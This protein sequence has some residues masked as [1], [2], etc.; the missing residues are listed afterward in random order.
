MKLN[1]KRIFI[2]ILLTFLAMKVINVLL[3][4]PIKDVVQIWPLSTNSDGVRLRIPVGYINSDVMWFEPI[5]EKDKPPKKPN[6]KTGIE[7]FRAWWPTMQPVA[8]NLN[9]QQIKQ[10][11]DKGNELLGIMAVSYDKRVIEKDYRLLHKLAVYLEAEFS[12]MLI[13]DDKKKQL[14]QWLQT[15]PISELNLLQVNDIKADAPYGY[16][17]NIGHRI[18]NAQTIFFKS[19]KVG[20]W[21][22][23]VIVCDK[24]SP[25]NRIEIEV[26]QQ[27]FLIPELEMEV[28]VHYTKKYLAQW[29]LIQQKTTDMFLS[30]KE[31]H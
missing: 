6:E 16:Y 10:M 2:I 21:P 22:E 30:F 11:Q 24:K 20:Q 29:S 15:T 17:P 25:Q 31:Q 23:V 27:S 5:L 7:L 19:S 18:A 12:A 9:Y 14:L 4:Q 3:S 8:K 26:C 13:F 28:K 1:K